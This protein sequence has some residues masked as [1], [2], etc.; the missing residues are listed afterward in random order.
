MLFTSFI[1]WLSALCLTLIKMILLVQLPPL[2]YLW[3]NLNQ[4][5]NLVYGLALH[6]SMQWNA[7]LDL[8]ILRFKS[9]WALQL[10]FSFTC[11]ML[12]ITIFWK[13]LNQYFFSI[14]KWLPSFVFLFISVETF[15]QHVCRH[16][17]YSLFSLYHIKGCLHLKPHANGSDIVGCYMLHPFAQPIACC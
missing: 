3:L 1:S 6:R 7:H 8:E 13:M 4:C 15:N 10:F 11:Y 12:P 5:I 14:L 17:L 2:L 9:C 16:L